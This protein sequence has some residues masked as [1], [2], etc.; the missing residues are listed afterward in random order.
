MYIKTVAFYVS[1]HKLLAKIVGINEQAVCSVPISFSF[2]VHVLEL[3]YVSG[4]NIFKDAESK[5][6][7]FPLRRP[8]VL[9]QTAILSSLIHDNFFHC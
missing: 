8:A 5:S 4:T 6:E 7:E 1:F 9:S 3:K 2:I